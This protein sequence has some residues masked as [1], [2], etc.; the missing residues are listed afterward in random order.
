MQR[1]A[2]LTR[3]AVGTV[4]ALSLAGCAGGKIRLD[5]AKSCQAHGGTWSQAQETCTASA[6]QASKQARDICVAQ[7]GDYLPGG[8]CMLEGTK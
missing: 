4:L 2:L 3:V 6:S 7:G 5:L 1:E 8:T